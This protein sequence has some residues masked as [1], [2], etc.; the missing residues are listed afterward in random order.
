MFKQNYINK[1]KK[2]K[3]IFN[4]NNFVLIGSYYNQKKLNF[5]FPNKIIKNI[6]FLLSNLFSM[7]FN[8]LLLDKNQ[9]YNYLPVSK[10]YLKSK[11]M[12]KVIK[13]FN[14]KVLLFL[15]LKPNTFKKFLKL[16]LLNITI[17]TKSTNT[18]FIDFSS[19]YKNTKLFHYML[20][21]H[22]LSLYLNK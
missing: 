22:I 1:N 9:N 20:Y 16:K 8:F 4:K 18:K 5:V 7:G 19:S 17:S 2:N 12:T 3:M 10:D 6:I 14:I 15:D 11:N 13:Y 21:I